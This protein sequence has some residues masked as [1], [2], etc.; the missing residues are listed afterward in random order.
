MQ[1]GRLV[2]VA[3]SGFCVAFCDNYAFVVRSVAL[4]VAKVVLVTSWVNCGFGDGRGAHEKMSAWTE[5]I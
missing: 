3:Q 5:I 1:R 4:A 2:A